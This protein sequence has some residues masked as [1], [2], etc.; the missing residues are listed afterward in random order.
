MVMVLILLLAGTAFWLA[1]TPDSGSQKMPELVQF[2]TADV[3]SMMLKQEA[4]GE[5]SLLRSGEKWL[6]SAGGAGDKQEVAD[7][8]AIRHLLDDLATMKIVRVVSRN[9]EKRKRLEMGLERLGSTK[10]GSGSTQVTLKTK[11]G[12]TVL[13]LFI[14]KQGSDLISTYIRMADRPEVLA[15]NRVLVWQVRRS[16][17]GWKAAVSASIETHAISEPYSEVK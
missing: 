12:N 17:Q 1:S 15:V 8:D 16:Y 5:I 13:D 7:V 11:D 6:L 3:Y 9:P 2:K 14:G 10:T 4:L